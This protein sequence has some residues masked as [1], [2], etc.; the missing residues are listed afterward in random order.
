M[1]QNGWHRVRPA[2]DVKNRALF[3]DLA[4]TR[5]GS[6]L[7]WQRSAQKS[8]LAKS[9]R[10]AYEVAN[11]RKSKAIAKSPALSLLTAPSLATSETLHD[12]A[13]IRR[14]ERDQEIFRP[15]E[16]SNTWYSVLSGAAREYIVHGDGRRQI[17]DIL[18]PGD[19]FGFTLRTHR[20]FGAQAVAKDTVVECYPRQRLEVLADT[21]PSTASE[22]RARCFQSIERLEE[23]MLV[24][25]TMTSKEKVHAFLSYFCDRL[26]AVDDGAAIP[27][28]RY[29]I[30]DTLGISVETVC[31]AFTELQDRGIITLQGPRR[32]KITRN[33]C[34][35]DRSTAARS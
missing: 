15:D 2:L 33:T 19:F 23:Q 22:I 17:I 3:D 34:D 14:F 4:G 9:V 5:T 6:F 18:L 16:R 13:H 26:A 35:Q 21:D 25:G 10:R 28:S 27:I 12:I 8:N 29:D 32:I 7:S 20:W 11:F 30:A 24:I 31:R 1:T